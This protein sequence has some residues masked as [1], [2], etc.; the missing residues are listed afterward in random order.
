MSTSEM[1]QVER[2]GKALDEEWAS[3]YPFFRFREPQPQ[4]QTKNEE[5][6]VVI[7][8]TRRRRFSENEADLNDNDTSKKDGLLV[9]CFVSCLSLFA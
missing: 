7:N 8:V 5:A 1:M 2:L 3:R 9:S 4:M 6:F